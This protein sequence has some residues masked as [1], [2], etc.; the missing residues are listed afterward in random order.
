MDFY[1]YSRKEINKSGRSAFACSVRE[2]TA[3]VYPQYFQNSK[4]LQDDEEPVFDETSRCLPG[5]HITKDGCQH[6]I[7]VHCTTQ[8]TIHILQV[9]L[10]LVEEFRRRVKQAVIADPTRPVGQ[11]YEAEMAK[12]TGSL[13]GLDREDFIALCPTLR[14]MERNLYR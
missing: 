14:T 11:T 6:P 5:D 1:K 3:R 2:C 10:R 12:M 8:K 4:K 9:D 7:Q 13:E